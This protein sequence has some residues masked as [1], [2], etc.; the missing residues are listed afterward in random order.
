ML[1]RVIGGP[2]GRLGSSRIADGHAE[3]GAGVALRILRLNALGHTKNG[4][5]L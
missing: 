3:A 5:R 2:A 4:F 1:P